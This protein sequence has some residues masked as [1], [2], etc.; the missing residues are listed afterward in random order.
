MATVSVW[1]RAVLHKFA[2]VPEDQSVVPDWLTEWKKGLQ[3][4]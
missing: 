2:A 4:R 3:K 1:E